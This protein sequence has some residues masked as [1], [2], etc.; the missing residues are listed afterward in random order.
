MIRRSLP[1]ALT[2]FLASFPNAARAQASPGLHYAR[3]ADVFGGANGVGASLEVS[4]PLL[5]LDAFVAGEYFFT[6]CAS[7]ADCSF[8]GGSA[9]VHFTMPVPVLTPYGA[10]GLVYRRHTSGFDDIVTRDDVGI[11]LGAGV[12]LGA[13][14]LGGYAE[15]RYEFVETDDQLV[16]RV[17]VRF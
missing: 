3:A 8:W 7:G 1:V 14:V 16:F 4:F 12:N 9:D 11:G 2:L 15:V 13:V 17:G 10:A 6:D 5:P